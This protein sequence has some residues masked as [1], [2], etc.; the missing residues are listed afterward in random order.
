MT[1]YLFTKRVDD[2]TTF[3]AVT[4][5]V[6]SLFGLDGSG[7]PVMI[8]NT[9]F[10]TALVSGTSIKTV[11]GTSLLGMGDLVISGGAG[12][13]DGDKGSIT[14]SGAGSTW[15]I[16]SGSVTND[17]LAGGIALGKLT[18]DPL[19]RANH[20]NT[21]DLSTISGLGGF[22]P[23]ALGITVGN[24]GAF[25][26][27]GGVGGTP[28]SLTL[29]NATGLPLTTGVTGTLA[30]ANGGTGS[31]DGSITGTGALTFTS[32]AASNINLTPGTTGFVDVVKTSGAGVRESILRAKVSDAGNDAFHIY[33]A[34]TTDGLFVPGFSGYSTSSSVFATLQFVGQCPAAADTGANPMVVFAARRTDSPTDPNNGSLTAITTRPAFRFQTQG[35]SY[36]TIGATGITEVHATTASTS[37]TTGSLIIGNGTTAT[38]VGIGGGNI[39][40]GGNVVAS[41]YKRG[42]GSPE[43]VITGIVGDLYTRTDGGAGTTLYVKESGTGNTGWV[44]K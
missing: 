14:V 25:V 26:V 17:M 38:T 3:P 1:T 24:P 40:A 5:A 13:T 7:N 36:L 23:T 2:V 12:V 10:Q 15:T 28:S 34:T 39:N 22:V 27:N 30:V 33:N 21:Q 4:Q 20:T 16:N 43:G 31:T 19:D 8:E 44:A 32:A 41:N 9:T 6:S 18:T 29:T 37:T 11:N 42:S 35:V